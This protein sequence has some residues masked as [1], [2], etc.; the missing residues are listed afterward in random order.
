MNCAFVGTSDDKGYTSFNELAHQYQEGKQM[1]PMNWMFLSRRKADSSIFCH[2]EN[3]MI[4]PVS[5]SG[6]HIC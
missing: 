3:D 2:K 1:F 4:F 6:L 5:F